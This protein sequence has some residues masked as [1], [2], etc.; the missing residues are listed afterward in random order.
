MSSTSQA[1][2]VLASP[3]ATRRVALDTDIGEGFGVWGTADESPLMELVSAA[4]VA[5]GFHAGDPDIL[6]RTCDQAAALG[7]SIG[8]Q[9]S[10]RDLAGFGRRFIDVSPATLV[11]EI[12]YQIGALQAFARIAGS[13]VTYVK[14]H[15][16]LYNTAAH[17]DGHASAIVQAV[18]LVDPS[19]PVLCQFG[20]RL[21]ML[22][23]EAGLCPRAEAFLDRG[24][25][26]DGLLVSRSHPDALITVPEVAAGRALTL[27][28]DGTV[29]SV[30]GA[31]VRV[32][33]P[34]DAPVAL[35]VHS[36]TA[37]AEAIA[38]ATRTTLRDAGVPL[39]PIGDIR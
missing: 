17:H 9:V 14:A 23:A 2:G 27:V 7:V 8:A 34:G 6:R 12:V 21:W 38:L 29:E 32:V 35:C 31:A 30:S 36:D 11:N 39:R 20:T 13:A 1:D 5:C 28:R 25:T 18:R 16:A 19:L 15:G 26:D 3:P 10:Y 4:N 33:P 37:G 24:Y 22:A